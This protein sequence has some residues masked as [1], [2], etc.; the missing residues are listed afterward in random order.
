MQDG[1]AFVRLGDGD[2]SGCGRVDE[3][4]TVVRGGQMCGRFT[5]WGEALGAAEL[6][7]LRVS[8]VRKLVDTLHNPGAN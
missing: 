6:H 5:T 4:Y 1:V 3:F 8:D 2:R 7:V